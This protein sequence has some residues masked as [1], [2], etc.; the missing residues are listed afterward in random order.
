MN[1]KNY[2]NFKNSLAKKGMR[3]GLIIKQLTS[4]HQIANKTS[5][6]KQ[7]SSQ[8]VEFNAKKKL[9]VA[10]KNLKKINNGKIQG[11]LRSVENE[12]QQ[13]EEQTNSS[14]V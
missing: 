11:I 3:F 5:K 14:T 8:Y 12:D 10:R 9:K 4:S 2:R 1:A 13:A 6:S 7:I